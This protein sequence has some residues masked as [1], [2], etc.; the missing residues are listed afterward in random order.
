MTL[1]IVFLNIREQCAWIYP[2]SK[3]K[4][5]DAARV[6]IRSS[7]ALTPS[8]RNGK[9]LR[10]DLPASVLIVGKSLSGDLCQEALSPFGLEIHRVDLIGGDIIREG[11]QYA[12]VW[13]NKEYLADCLILTPE[14]GAELDHISGAVK[15]LNQQPLISPFRTD[16]ENLDYG[17]VICPPELDP[18]ICG[19]GAALSLF[20]WISQLSK[21]YY[22]S[23]AVVDPTRCRA[24]GTCRE[25]CGYG[26]PAKVTDQYGT[27]AQINNLL[28]KDCG[29]CSA[30]CPSGAITP[31]TNTVWELEEMLEKILT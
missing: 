15:L 22:P 11:G 18:E 23:A 13:E 17:L 16:Q 1:P 28:C 6:M 14:S 5:T 27:H 21:S 9:V 24:C 25:I 29:A 19:S 12:A 10:P 4:A 26:I 7:M 20:A 30:H 2:R 3:K 8:G 31:G